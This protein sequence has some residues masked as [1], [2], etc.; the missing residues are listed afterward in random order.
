MFPYLGMV[1][2]SKEVA[3]LQLGVMVQQVLTNASREG[4]RAAILDGSSSTSVTTTVQN[5]A[6][7][8]SISGVTVTT[9]P[10]D[11]S[12]AGAGDPVTVTVSVAFDQV[13][14]FPGTIF[15]SDSQQL[16]AST[17]MRRESAQ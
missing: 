9:S 14:W 16:A 8:A 11:P 17:V 2:L 7:S 13:S 15:L 5:Y 10:S 6:S 12:T 1:K 3:V 4:A